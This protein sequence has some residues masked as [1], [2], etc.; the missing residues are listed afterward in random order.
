MGAIGDFLAADHHRCDDLFADAEQ[1]AAAGDWPACVAA[2]EAFRLALEHHLGMEEAVLFPEF[3]TRTGMT[4]GPTAVMRGEHGQMREVCAQMTAC[5]QRRSGDEFLG[6]AEALLI[7]MQQH[8]LKEES[9]LYP[10]TERVLGADAAALVL[11]MGMVPE[12]A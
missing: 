1:A 12:K 10:M 2:T 8:N 11:R 9:V 6:H 4:G 3:E 7:L 5:A